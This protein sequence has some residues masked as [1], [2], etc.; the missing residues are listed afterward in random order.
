M[1][2][3]PVAVKGVQG[4][5][6]LV[7]FKAPKLSGQLEATLILCTGRFNRSGADRFAPGLAGFVVHSVLMV[8]EVVEFAFKH[9]GLFG[10]KFIQSFPQGFESFNDIGSSVCT[11]F[12][13]AHIRTDPGLGL[14]GF[15]AVEFSC[16]SPQMLPSMV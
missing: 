14:F 9:F 6:G 13:P 7:T 16:Q 15:R 1:G 2:P 8:P 3:S 10:R 12:K 11:A 4:Q 5:E